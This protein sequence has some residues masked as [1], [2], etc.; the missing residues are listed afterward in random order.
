MTAPAPLAAPLPFGEVERAALSVL[1]RLQEPGAFV[2][3]SRG[4][5]AG[6]V[7]VDRKPF[8]VR[9]LASVAPR[10]LLAFWS[11]GWIA[12]A[13]RTPRLA[14]Y[15]ITGE[16]RRA[17]RRLLDAKGAAR[18]VRAAEAGRLALA[19]GVLA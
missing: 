16:G 4:L 5:D 8:R 6:A 3:V 12:A 2:L 18:R 19:A 7:F 13:R 9:R 14:R 11:R 1:R 10:V 17:L 15:E